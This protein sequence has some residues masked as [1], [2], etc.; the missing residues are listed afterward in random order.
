MKDTKIPIVLMLSILFFAMC[1]KDSPTT[2]NP[3]ANPPTFTGFSPE[4]GFT[5]DTITL[6]G[7]NF[8]SDASVKFGT[9]TAKVIKVN[10]TTISVV[11]PEMSEI[12]VPINIAVNKTELKSA[13]DFKRNSPPAEFVSFTPKN[14]YIGDTITLTVKYPSFDPHVSFGNEEAEIA[15]KEGNI[16]KAVVPDKI[17]DAISKI[18]LSYGELLLTHAD[19]FKL[20]PPVI[21]SISPSLGFNR[22]SVV[23]TGKGF[24]NTYA[25]GQI[26][27]VNTLIEGSVVQPGHTSLRFSVPGNAAAGKYDISV[28]VAGMKTTV[29]NAYE[30]IVPVITSVTPDTVSELGSLVI[31]G[32]HL[33]DING[34]STAVF[35]SE[36]TSGL[37]SRA[38]YITSL[39]DTGIHVALTSQPQQKCRLTVSVV[40]SY[41]D[42]EKPIIIKD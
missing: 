18:S 7:T 29:A 5:G 3:A 40:G 23:I 41:V 27:W 13:K 28:E 9:V 34:G 4:S 2:K 11:V 12:L 10:N 39:T 25:P 26:F 20:N 38:V 24:R 8:T 33:K 36:Y 15:S 19:E 42:Y 37:N 1:K 32:T 17:K 31:K 21:T 30:V 14:A 22:Q 35:L 16:I 6:T